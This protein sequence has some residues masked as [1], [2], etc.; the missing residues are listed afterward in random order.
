ME[1]RRKKKAEREEARKASL[2]LLSF[3]GDEK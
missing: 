2:S 1:R 3:G